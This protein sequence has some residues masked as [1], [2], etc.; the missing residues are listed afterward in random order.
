[1]SEFSDE[2]KALFSAGRADL[3]PS[4]GDR[5]RV[6]RA[7]AARLGAV[8]LGASASAS[9]GGTAAAAATTAKGS[10]GLVLKWVGVGALIGVGAGTSYVAFKGA[11][12]ETTA[13]IASNAPAASAKS[14]TASVPAARAVEPL[15][16]IGQLPEREATP[17][18]KAVSPASA[19]SA[20]GARVGEEAA[21]LRK[22]H[23]ALRAGNGDQ[24]VRLLREHAA[25][26][27]AG[28]LSQERSAQ[29]VAA[30]CS[31]GRDGE[32]RREAQLFLQRNP[33]SVLA[34][35]V[36]NSCAGPRTN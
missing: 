1:M 5:A 4:R 11:S 14:P 33:S 32:A 7:L 13:A 3:E 27:P 16:P 6:R 35:T 12:V 26:F 34:T 36:R 2:S 25:R 29:L 20:P 24:A 9:L 23:E 15:P 17:Q 30:L 22:A 31:L 18:K 8:A 19:A 28:I 21:L 10:F